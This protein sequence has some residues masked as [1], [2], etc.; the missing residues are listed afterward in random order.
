MK[1]DYDNSEIIGLCHVGMYARNPVSLA[2][3]YRDVMGLQKI[4]LKFRER[5]PDFLFSAKVKTKAS[6]ETN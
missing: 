2:V 4:L 6:L 1:A 3:F 5:N